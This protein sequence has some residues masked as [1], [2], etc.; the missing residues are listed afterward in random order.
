MLLEIFVIFLQSEFKLFINQ[1]VKFMKTKFATLVLCMF[2][3]LHGNSQSDSFFNYQSA[4]RA[5]NTTPVPFYPKD[6]Q[7]I[8]DMNVTVPIGNGTMIFTIVSAFY[9]FYRRKESAR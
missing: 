2:F 5:V 4:E 1:K 3:A 9:V 8:Q 6:G 7:G